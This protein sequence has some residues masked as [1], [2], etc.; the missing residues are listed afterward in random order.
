MKKKLT[1][2]EKDALKHKLEESGFDEEGSKPIK[3]T[4]S[5][6]KKEKMKELIA[7]AEREKLERLD[8]NIHSRRAKKK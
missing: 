1:T 3:L 8:K 7:Q 6:D 2:E 4:L 5:D